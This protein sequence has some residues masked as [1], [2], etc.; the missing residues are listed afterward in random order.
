[1]PTINFASSTAIVL[2]L[3]CVCDAFQGNW[4]RA[5]NS[6]QTRRGSSLFATPCDRRAFFS[7]LAFSPLLIT[8]GSPALAE[9]GQDL[10]SQLFNPDGSIKEGVETEAKDR[11]LDFTWEKSD[12]LL[13]SVDG[14]NKEG[15][16]AGSYVKISYKLP[17]KWGSGKDL[18]IDFSEGANAKACK[19]I[20]VYKA[21]GKATM[22]RLQKATTIG[23]GKALDVTDDLSKIRT[24]DIIGGRTR[25]ADDGQKY[26]AFDMASAPESCGQSKDNL[27]LG[28]C[29][30]DS[31]YLLSA[32]IIEDSLY[33]I[34]VECDNNEWKQGNADLKR[35]RNSFTVEL[36]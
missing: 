20:T 2:A 35:V 10:T 11:T 25:I 6:L 5:E 18:Y 29:P 34:A 32:T 33:V 14:T 8:A 24:A 26:F 16:A 12:N 7:G 3:I 9:E 13:V 30:Y 21:P 22:D 17:E 36:I 19:R 28:F 23:I 4:K 15:S 31:I 1:M 27:G